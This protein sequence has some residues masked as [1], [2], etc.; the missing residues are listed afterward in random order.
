M[1][2][3]ACRNGGTA[4]GPPATK[5]K[6][7]GST[8]RSSCKHTASAPGDVR[9]RLPLSCPPAGPANKFV[10]LDSLARISASRG[11]RRTA[12][13]AALA[14]LRRRHLQEM[15]FAGDQRE[16]DRL[17]KSRAR[18]IKS[19]MAHGGRKL[20]AFLSGVWDDG[21]SDAGGRSEVGLRGLLVPRTMGAAEAGFDPVEMRLAKHRLPHLSWHD[22]WIWHAQQLAR[23]HDLSYNPFVLSK[24]FKATRVQ[25]YAVVYRGDRPVEKEGRGQCSKAPC[26]AARTEAYTLAYTI[27]L[28][29]H[30]PF[31]LVVRVVRD[32]PAQQGFV[33]QQSVASLIQHCLRHISSQSLVTWASTGRGLRA[34]VVETVDADTGLKI[35]I[36]HLCDEALRDKVLSGEMAL[37]AIFYQLHRASHAHQS[38]KFA[39]RPRLV[40]LEIA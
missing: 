35:K 17:R 25:G 19:L 20:D 32:K 18:K 23:A 37:S 11:V 34:R 31:E 1:L 30:M 7:A 27:G 15:V 14:V 22:R 3:L 38:R 8:A 39:P 29:V 5:T 40:Q 12:T 13:A 36:S 2:V 16:D 10:R 24:M 26:N 21:D 6:S 33:G 28:S 4:V 9:K